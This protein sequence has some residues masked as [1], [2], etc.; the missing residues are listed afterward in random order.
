MEHSPSTGIMYN[1]HWYFLLWFLSP[2]LSELIALKWFYNQLMDLN[3]WFRNHCMELLGV[4][5][6]RKGTCITMYINEGLP[7]LRRS[8]PG[9]Q[10][11]LNSALSK[12]GSASGESSLSCPKRENTVPREHQSLRWTACRLASDT[13]E[14]RQARG[15]GVQRSREGIQS[16]KRVEEEWWVPLGKPMNTH[17]GD[18]GTWLGEGVHTFSGIPSS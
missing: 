10:C 4:F 2:S 17:H 8:C 1:E 3:L 6:K 11:L 12:V 14:M 9:K 16:T 13:E 5:S 18:H 15:A 7:S